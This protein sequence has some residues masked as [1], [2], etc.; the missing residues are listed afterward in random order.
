MKNRLNELEL[1]RTPT[2]EARQLLLVTFIERRE[3]ERLQKALDVPFLLDAARSLPDNP[4]LFGASILHLALRHGAP[5]AVARRLA[6][7]LPATPSSRDDAG[8]TPLHLACSADC[9]CTADVVEL[10]AKAAGPDACLARDHR[11]RLPLHYACGASRGLC[12]GDHVANADVVACL[13]T[14]APASVHVRDVG[15]ADAV[16]VAIQS[17]GDM[18]LVKFLQDISA[19]E[20]LR[21]Q[22]RADKELAAMRLAT[23]MP[24]C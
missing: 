15:D 10:L 7:L 20:H 24:W 6:R 16:E 11:G 4:A 18:R 14:V 19:I 8:R 5:L 3:W 21:K 13:L 9:G 1:L 17:S 2:S 23:M 22:R 12:S